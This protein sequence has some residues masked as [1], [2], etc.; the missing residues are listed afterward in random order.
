MDKVLFRRRLPAGAL[1]LFLLPAARAEIAGPPIV[2]NDYRLDLTPSVA[3]GPS[4]KVAMG[5]AYTAIAEGAAS[6]ADNPAGV[7]FRPTRSQGLVDWDGTLGGFRAQGNDLDNN[8]S[9]STV[10]KRDLT[11]NLGGL[12]QYGRFGAG[13]YLLSQR[14]DMTSPDGSVNRFEFQTGYMVVGGIHPSRDLSWGAGL[15]V[16]GINAT[17][18]G[19]RQRFFHLGGAGVTG[20]LLWNPERGPFRLGLA[21]HSAI[22]DEQDAVTSTTAVMA[23]G[24]V[25][26]RAVTMPEIASI[27]AAYTWNRTPYLA[28]H[29]LLI[30]ADVNYIG[31]VKEAVGIESFLEQRVQRSGEKASLG[32][33][34]GVEHEFLPRR[35]RLRGGTYYEPSRYAGISGRWHTTAGFELRLFKFNIF[36]EHH[37]SLGYAVDAAPRYLVQFVGLGFWQ[38]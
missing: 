5:G 15:R 31:R 23:A 27:G 33:H 29:P 32:H 13:L 21:F 6:I 19:S 3:I 9:Q 7:A 8:G 12:L 20:G 18:K 35:L 22:S 25:V 24:L 2:N 28:K 38:F 4:R 1:L 30:S 14:F 37:V 26:P 34:L 16:A 17:P 11:Y 10:F 36:G